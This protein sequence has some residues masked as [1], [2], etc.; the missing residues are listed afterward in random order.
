[1]ITSIHTIRNILINVSVLN[2]LNRIPNICVY[3]NGA[4]RT[5][6]LQ[7]ESL[8][9]K[10]YER[11]YRDSTSEQYTHRLAI[12]GMG[13][14]GKTQIAIEYVAKFETEYVGIYWITAS[15]E[16]E[17][18]S[19][20]QAIANETRC[21][22]T[23]S[24]TLSEIA[25]R[26]LNW[27]YRSKDWLLVLDN[28]DDITVAEGYL[29]RIR[30]DG[31][32]VLITTRNPNSLNIPAEGMQV[33]VHEPD[34]AKDLLLR[35]SQMYNE[36]G[37]G[38][39]VEEE[40][41]AIVKVLGYLALAIEQA[42]AYIRE[43]LKDIF[44]FC[45]IYATQRSQFHYR[46]SIGNTYYKNTIATTW[47]MSMEAI[48]SRNHQAGQLLRLLAFMNPDGISIGFLEA[49]RYAFPNDFNTGT[50][51]AF[52]TNLLKA[53]GDLEQFSLIFRPKPELILIHRMVQSVTKD[54]LLNNELNTHRVMMCNIG[55]FAFPEFSYEYLL[56]CREY[57]SQI[58]FIVMEIKDMRIG[59][60]AVL[61]R[62]VG[63]FLIEDGKARDGESLLAMALSS[64]REIFGDGHPETLL[65]MG[66]L[67]RSYSLLWS[68]QGSG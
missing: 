32:H 7:V 12:Y 55:L 29:P 49:G 36:I 47:L 3:H 52:I 28:L 23:E 37:S 42:A 4:K 24:L 44:K 58:V 54:R 13:G 10:V 57:Q 11:N 59:E 63:K 17:L 51:A 40:A 19:G 30:V 31:G 26:V 16:A 62:R 45:T 1:M 65:T 22:D 41:K 48:E 43:E 21:V 66:Q 18:L 60:A 53:L 25:R 34:E 6:I 15:S 8:F 27:L 64:E 68:E 35:R 50:E 2:H 20:F 46:Q 56:K 61:L 14:V 5:L 39:K 67:A 9:L 38:S 33:D